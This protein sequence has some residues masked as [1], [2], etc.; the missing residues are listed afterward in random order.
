M[1]FGC[2]GISG[3]LFW[4]FLKIGLFTFG[5]GYAMIPLI[6]RE[7]VERRGWVGKDEFLDLLALAQTAP[8]PISLNTAVSVGYSLNR[9]KGAL[10]AI[11][12]A[13]LPSL[14]II[15]LIAVYF[16]DIKDNRVVDAVFKGMRPAVVA[17]IVAPVA[18]LAKGMSLYR[19]GIALLAAAA[20]WQL[21]ISPAW[22]ILAGAA[23]GVIWAA[24]RRRR[25]KPEEDA[26]RRDTNENNPEK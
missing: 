1:C 21:G 25:A 2:S 16:S 10:A 20:V 18:G 8:G 5:G 14:V 9:Y 26:A 23:G 17:L 11:L 15:L 6:R 22:F 13:V 3:R 7:V 19:V 4:S 24:V 12:G